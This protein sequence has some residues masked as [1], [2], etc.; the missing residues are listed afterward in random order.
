MA[1][2]RGR[3]SVTRGA[4]AGPAAAAGIR[5]HDVIRGIAGDPVVGLGDLYRKLWGRGEAGIT[6]PLDVLQGLEV[7][8]VPVES[9][10]RYR[11]L[12]LEQSY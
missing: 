12:R 4:P 8:P 5:P 3:V 7:N 2:H 1:E 10:D 9:A 6:V 11:Y